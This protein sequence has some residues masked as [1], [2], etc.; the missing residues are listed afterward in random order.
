MIGNGRMASVGASIVT[1]RWKEQAH[2]N[3][4]RIDTVPGV[5]FARRFLRHVLPGALRSTR[6]YGFCHPAGKKRRERI[7]FHTGRPFFR[8]PPR[9]KPAP[10]PCPCSGGPLVVVRRIRPA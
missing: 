9:P 2:G 1:F 5:E 10:S 6:Q 7:A 4:R 3:L 8:A